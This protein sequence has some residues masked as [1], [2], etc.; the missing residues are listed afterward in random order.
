MAYEGVALAEAQHGGG[1]ESG[2][3]PTP[4]V[5]GMLRHPVK[6]TQMHQFLKD[7]ARAM[8]EQ[9]RKVAFSMVAASRWDHKTNKFTVTALEKELKLKNPPGIYVSHDGSATWSKC[10]LGRNIKALDPQKAQEII[11]G[12]VAGDK[13]EL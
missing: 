2:A 5:L 9:E 7:S 3:S 4:L 8:A 11:A 6:G 1:V 13:D 12:C 10:D